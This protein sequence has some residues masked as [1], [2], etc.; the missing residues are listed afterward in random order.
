MAT[1][2]REYVSKCDIC[3]SHCAEQTKEPLLQHDVTDRPWSKV[4]A[5]LCEQDNR[6]LLVTVDYYSNFVEVARLSSVTSCSVIKEMKATFPRYGIPYVLITDNGLQ[7]ASAEFA[8]FAK[9]WMFQHITSSPYHPQS[10]G[11]AENASQNS[12]ASL[13]Q[14]P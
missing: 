7:F 12:E 11:K 2:L 6:T 13:Y 5:D 1:E 8:V 9:S 3:L 4:M 10:N 14:M